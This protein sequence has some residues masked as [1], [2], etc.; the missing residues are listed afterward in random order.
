M[1]A[2][3]RPDKAGF[4]TEDACRHYF[5]D[6]AAHENTFNV[7]LCRCGAWHGGHVDTGRELH[8]VAVRTF[9]HTF[10]LTVAGRLDDT[11]RARLED[12]ATA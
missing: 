4:T 10:D 12:L 5:A 2:C 1:T 9:G 7:Y 8:L 3:P 6:L 11:L